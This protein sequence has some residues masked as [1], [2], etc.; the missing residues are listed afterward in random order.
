MDLTTKGKQSPLPPR[1]GIFSSRMFDCFPVVVCVYPPNKFR[2]QL[3]HA[4]ITS[5]S[6]RTD[7]LSLAPPVIFLRLRTK[8]HAALNMTDQQSFTSS[9]NGRPVSGR[10]R[11]PIGCSQKTPQNTGNSMRINVMFSFFIIAK[12]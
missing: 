11:I 1:R 2:S 9:L 8:E 3:P 12:R 4:S 5:H 10:G 7:T 6:P